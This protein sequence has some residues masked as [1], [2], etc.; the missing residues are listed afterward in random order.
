MGGL[1]NYTS[2]ESL[3]KDLVAAIEE[4]RVV[5]LIPDNLNSTYITLILKVDRPTTFVE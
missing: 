1:W 5:G 4:Y 2:F 3:G